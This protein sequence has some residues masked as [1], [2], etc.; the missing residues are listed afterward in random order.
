MLHDI[1]I[2]PLHVFPNTCVAHNSPV[3][4]RTALA[5]KEDYFCG[6]HFFQL[7]STASYIKRCV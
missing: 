5:A 3:S 7:Y 2:G 1:I 4:R 6:Y